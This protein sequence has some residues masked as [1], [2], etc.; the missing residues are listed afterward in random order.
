MLTASDVAAAAAV[1]WN[2]RAPGG[3]PDAVRPY[4]RRPPSAAH[5]ARS[6]AV[7]RAVEDKGG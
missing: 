4:R 7:A 6:A 1:G 3:G 2:V 5:A